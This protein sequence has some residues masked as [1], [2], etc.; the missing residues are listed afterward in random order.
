MADR[1][2]L[3]F[4]L[5]LMPTAA[6]AQLSDVGVSRR[7]EPPSV[8]WMS[9]ACAARRWPG[10]PSAKG[11]GGSKSTICGATAKMRGTGIIPSTM[12]T[13]GVPA[14]SA[15]VSRIES[16]HHASVLVSWRALG[17][18]RDDSSVSVLFGGAY[19]HAKQADCFASDGPVV[20]IPTPADWP[21]GI[22]SPSFSGR[23]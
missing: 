5:I 10:R 15:P 3:A 16:Q 23:S 18:P 13:G 19:L 1:L 22:P 11:A 6:A 20:R 2:A 14:S 9:G 8:R 17:R 7:P 4:A 12:S 21:P